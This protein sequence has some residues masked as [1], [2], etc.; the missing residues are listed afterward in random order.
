MKKLFL[1]VVAVLFLATGAAHADDKLPENMLGTW[2]QAL[3]SEIRILY[4]RP[5]FV[6]RQYCDDFHDGIGLSQ[7]GFSDGRPIDQCDEYV[8]DKIEQ[9]QDGYLV[10]AH[11]EKAFDAYDPNKDD[12]AGTLRLQLIHDDE[13]LIATRMPGQRTRKSKSKKEQERYQ[14]ATDFRHCQLEKVFLKDGKDYFIDVGDRVTV[15][16][17]P[18]DIPEI[19]RG[20]KELKKCNAFWQCVGKRDWPTLSEDMRKDLPDPL[21]PGEKRP[22]H[23]YEN[24]R[25]WR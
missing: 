3:H 21:K 22:K 16:I 17:D 12:L 11:C 18:E 14:W 15:G 2:C 19:E 13:L 10:S 9:T 6:G 5:A 24:D 23:C 7:S 1:P 25:R 8:F 20:L 4:F